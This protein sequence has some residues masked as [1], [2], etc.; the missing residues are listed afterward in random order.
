MQHLKKTPPTNGA[1]AM[2][3]LEKDGSEWFT[4]KHV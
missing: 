3:Q 4:F 2:G 1:M